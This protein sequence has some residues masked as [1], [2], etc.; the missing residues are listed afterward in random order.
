MIFRSVFSGIEFRLNTEES[1]RRTFTDGVET[2]SLTR[3]GNHR[4]TTD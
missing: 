3:G 2:Q 1:L 4:V